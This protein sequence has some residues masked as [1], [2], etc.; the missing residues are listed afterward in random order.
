[1]TGAGSRRIPRTTL[2]ADANVLIDYRDAGELE[3]LSLAAH[4]L[5]RLAVVS[6][7]LG[8]VRDVTAEDCA[9]L[10][11][12]VVEASTEQFFQA[13]DLGSNV[14]FNDALC[15]VVCRDGGWTCVTNDRALQRL[16]QQR[17]VATRFG[18]GLLVDLVA[19]KAITRGRAEG[20]SRQIQARNPLHIHE[21]VV[22]R[23]RMELDRVQR[24]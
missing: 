1:M 2:L 8:E 20:V 4:H 24:N 9:Q 18:L 5:G 14:S 23:L 21:R 16:C 7:V 17:G 19:A 10:G 3:I 22:A 6:E 11:V 12:E 15:L 13:R